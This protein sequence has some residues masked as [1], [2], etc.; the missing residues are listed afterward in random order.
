MTSL[1]QL[2]P[3]CLQLGLGLEA[4]QRTNCGYFAQNPYLLFRQL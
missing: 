1:A 3:T 2:G 4:A